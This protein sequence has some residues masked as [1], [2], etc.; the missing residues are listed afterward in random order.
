METTDT[1]ESSKAT[2]PWGKGL[3]GG[4]VLF[5][6]IGAQV[7]YTLGSS[8]PTGAETLPLKSGGTITFLGTSFGTEHVPPEP[9]HLRLARKL[10]EPV[11]K[12]LKISTGAAAIKTPL[13]TLAVWTRLEGST[14]ASHT[15]VKALADDTGYGVE[16]SGSTSERRGAAGET[17]TGVA[18]KAFPRRSPVITFRLTERDPQWKRVGTLEWRFKNPAHGTFPVWTAEALPV[19]RTVDDLEIELRRVVTGTSASEGGESDCRATFQVRQAGT[20]L[21]H[22]KPDGVVM[23][24]AT[25]N[26]LKQSSWGFE[27][28]RQEETVTF[29]FSPR[30]W[31]EEPAWKMRF[32]FVRVPEAEFATN[33]LW[34]IKGIPV[35]AR[36][37][38][39]ELNLSSNL[40]GHTVRVVGLA[41]REG[42]F[43][44][45]DHSASGGERF[46]VQVSPPLL[47][48]QIDLVRVVDEQGRAGKG[49]RSSWSR[50][51]GRYGFRVEFHNEAKEVDVTF[52]VHPC[53]YAEFTVRPEVLRSAASPGQP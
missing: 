37:N 2:F 15:F 49:S 4:L 19:V 8:R 27:S 52:A 24:D 20:P 18:F 31:V 51:A 5:A 21:L 40:L 1:G 36:T 9:L 25:G 47:D 39:T 50:D 17:L 53:V 38:V 16:V 23:T 33:E 48:K 10:P 13:P 11:R 3:I 22:W 28:E 29:R 7:W 32:E 45:D 30:L 14:A 43:G 26:E 42:R 6:L 46:V 44:R 12:A 35:P 41:G 34:T